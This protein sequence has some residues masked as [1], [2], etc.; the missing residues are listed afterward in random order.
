MNYFKWRQKLT[1]YVTQLIH[2][3][4]HEAVYEQDFANIEK[5]KELLRFLS[6]QTSKDTKYCP[7]CGSGYL[8]E[9][10]CTNPR[11]KRT[12][13]DGIQQLQDNTFT[14]RRCAKCGYYNVIWT[15]QT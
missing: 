10:H 7:Y 8:E 4:E 2:I 14:I 1:D 13:R 6:M 5:T 12:L 3:Q 15:N 11:F 9:L